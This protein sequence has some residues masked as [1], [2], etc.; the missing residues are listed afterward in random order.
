MVVTDLPPDASFQFRGPDGALHLR[1]QNLALFLQMAEGVDD[2]TWLFHLHRGDYSAWL[3]NAYADE[4]LAAAVA[5][6][7][8]SP[9]IGAAESR[10]RIRRAIAERHRVAGQAEPA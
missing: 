4:A 6:V 8:R 10:A 2:R 9:A 1:A 5:S 7:E 3:R